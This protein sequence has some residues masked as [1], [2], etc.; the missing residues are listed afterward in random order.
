MIRILSRDIIQH[1]EHLFEI[2]KKVKEEDFP[3][4][5]KAVEVA[6]TILE[7]DACLRSNK[8]NGYLLFCRSIDE[9]EIINEEV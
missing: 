6:K 1:N 7:C 9:V 8:F 5:N 3:N 2:I 4:N